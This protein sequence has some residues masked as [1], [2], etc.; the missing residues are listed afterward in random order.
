MFYK[1]DFVDAAGL[2]YTRRNY[3]ATMLA[4]D[5]LRDL[6]DTDKHTKNKTKEK[7]KHQ[8]RDAH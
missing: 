6:N 1:P 3:T 7:K 8:E 2:I 5:S 4:D